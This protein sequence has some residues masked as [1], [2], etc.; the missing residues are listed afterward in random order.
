MV[1]HMFLSRTCAGRF[2]KKCADACADT[3]AAFG[4]DHEILSQVKKR[5]DI[6][7]WH[8]LA[9]MRDCMGI[10]SRGSPSRE[11]NHFP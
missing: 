1:F 2:A 6:Q 9:S 4:F 8:I 10:F 3:C 7:Y 11:P 5:G